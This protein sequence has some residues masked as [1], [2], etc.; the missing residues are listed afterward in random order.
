MDWTDLRNH[1][2]ESARKERPQ[3]EAWA[4]PAMADAHKAANL[5][6][7]NG[8]SDAGYCPKDGTPFLAWTPTMSLPFVCYYQGKWPDGKWWA[9]MDGDVWPQNPGPVLWKPLPEET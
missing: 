4:H 2:E 7:A 9:E 6:R 3:R 8:W 1:W 5:L